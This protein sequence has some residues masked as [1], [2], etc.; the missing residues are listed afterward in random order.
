MRTTTGEKKKGQ[1]RE[2]TPLD[3]GP[4]PLTGGGPSLDLTGGR[5]DPHGAATGEREDDCQGGGEWA[6]IGG[7]GG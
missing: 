2:G 1:W 4:D 3:D 5:D 6:T 7:G